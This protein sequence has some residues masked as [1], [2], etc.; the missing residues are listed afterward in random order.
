M[1]CLKGKIEYIISISVGILGHG[2]CGGVGLTVVVVMGG[3]VGSL[4]FLFSEDRAG[5]DVI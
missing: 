1:E 2:T 3:Q 5:L 4:T